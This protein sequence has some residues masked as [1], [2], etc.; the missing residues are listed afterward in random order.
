MLSFFKQR[1]NPTIK[2]PAFA[3]PASSRREKEQRWLASIGRAGTGADARSA[4]RSGGMSEAGTSDTVRLGLGVS[5]GSRELKSVGS[6]A[7]LKSTGTS[8][9]RRSF[10]GGKDRATAQAPIPTFD[11]LTNGFDPPRQSSPFP[12]TPPKFSLSPSRSDAERNLSPPRNAAQPSSH[13]SLSGRQ[14]DGQQA[15]VSVKHTA[16]RPDPNTKSLASRLQELSNSNADG[17]LGDDEYRMLRTQLFEVYASASIQ[18][19]VDP[20]QVTE[21]FPRLGTDHPPKPLSAPESPTRSSKPPS[22]PPPLP[23]SRAHS[24]RSSA[25]ASR[26]GFSSLFRRPPS[27]PVES[28]WEVV[29]PTRLDS[30]SIIGASGERRASRVDALQVE[31]LG[32]VRPRSLRNHP[33]MASSSFSSYGG[34][35]GGSSRSSNGF[36]SEGSLHGRSSYSYSPSKRGTTLPS[37]SIGGRSRFESE[38]PSSLP[39]LASSSD[40]FLFATARK[41]PTS[42]ELRAEISEIEEEWGRVEESWD[43]LENSAIM[44]WENRLGPSGLSAMANIVALRNAAAPRAALDS[45]K[46]KP[47]G[48]KASFTFGRERKPPPSSSTR[49]PLASR[50]SHLPQ[51]FVSALEAPMVVGASEEVETA[52]LALREELEE[53]RKKRR[54]TE[55]RYQQRLDFLRAKLRGALIREKLPH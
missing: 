27:S 16:T 50:P 28:D 31:E 12:T 2:E 6:S 55:E 24:V 4:G 18:D 35:A 47:L 42:A 41:D 33:G 38:A 53:V 15:T 39:P 49:P 3:P 37:S 32:P 44:K 43:G 13:L 23:N 17:L 10:W 22:T 26:N 25:S 34:G 54:A 14:S 36:S 46:K 40:P 9:S 19:T 8:K 30:N 21:G 52:T 29:S 1:P 51:A 11:G 5:D 20:G 48:R 7:S 45:N